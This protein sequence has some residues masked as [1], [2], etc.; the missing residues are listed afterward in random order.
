MTA[1]LIARHEQRVANAVAKLKRDGILALSDFL[2]GLDAPWPA[3]EEEDVMCRKCRWKC[4]QPSRRKSRL[5]LFLA[6][7]RLHPFRC[8]SCG[9]RY[10]RLAL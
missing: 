5:D 6:L 9:H 1:D 3:G 8:R 10:Y 7:F 4:S 2:R